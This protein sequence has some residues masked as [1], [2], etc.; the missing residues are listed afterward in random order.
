MITIILAHH[1]VLD[2]LQSVRRRLARFVRTP[3][4][5]VDQVSSAGSVFLFERLPKF[6]PVAGLEHYVPHD[7]M[8]GRLSV[9]P[10]HEETERRE[11][12]GRNRFCTTPRHHQH[13]DRRLQQCLYIIYI[14]Y[15]VISNIILSCGL[16][17]V[18]NRYNDEKTQF[19]VTLQQSVTGNFSRKDLWRNV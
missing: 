7:R 14:L 6:G 5:A 8:Y 4:Q 19:L 11:P 15:R 18:G 13:G 10:G 17:L 12:F 16:N 2:V 9:S 1:D 3:S